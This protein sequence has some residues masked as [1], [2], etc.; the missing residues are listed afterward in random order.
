MTERDNLVQAASEARTHAY[1]PYS[2]FPV[3][4]AVM[5]GS[6]K[7]YTGCNIENASYGL[8][9]CAERTAVFN[10]ISA[11]ER[12]ISTVAVVADTPAPTAPCGACRQ[13]MA[14]F[15]VQTI[16]MAN[17]TGLIRTVAM[18]ELLPYAFGRNDLGVNKRED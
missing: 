11:G 15:G 14:E 17:T 3:G 18:N 16:I 9:V 13:V 12:Q 5:G 2:H 8:T 4:A 10:A 1:V 6:G 7:L